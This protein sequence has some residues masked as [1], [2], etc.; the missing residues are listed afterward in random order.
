MQPTGS[1]EGLSDR[2]GTEEIEVDVGGGRHIQ[3]VMG[4]GNFQSAINSNY[5]TDAYT[6]GIQGDVT[7][8]IY[9]APGGSV[10]SVEVLD[11]DDLMLPE[12]ARKYAHR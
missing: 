11:S 12:H 1:G 9:F 3:L 10:A 4:T 7:L 5:P 2:E 6:M 8:R